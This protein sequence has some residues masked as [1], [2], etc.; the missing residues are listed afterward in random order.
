MKN[1]N[2]IINIG[3]N[4][5]NTKKDRCM[6]GKQNGGKYRPVPSFFN[7]DQFRCCDQRRTHWGPKS[8]KRDEKKKIGRCPIKIGEKWA[9]CGP[10]SPA[11]PG[12]GQPL[13]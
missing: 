4:Q 3:E 8:P 12:S 1:P 10:G 9:D 7:I 6:M 2:Q 13:V 11:G 5:Q